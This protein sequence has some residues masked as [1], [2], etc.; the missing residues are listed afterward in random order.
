[1]TVRGESIR[2]KCL[3]ICFFFFLSE[4]N[5]TSTSIDIHTDFVTTVYCNFDLKNVRRWKLF[6]QSSCLTFVTFQS[7][8]RVRNF[9]PENW[10][11]VCAR[12]ITDT[13]FSRKRIQIRK[14]SRK[15]VDFMPRARTRCRI[16]RMTVGEGDG[17]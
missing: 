4:K 11:L 8:V 3:I 13:K 9:L 17:G 1:M 10:R 14:R 2:R 12:R 5:V 6:T 16:L 15:I 7:F